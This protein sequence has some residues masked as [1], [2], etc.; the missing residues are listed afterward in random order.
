MTRAI[1]FRI[2]ALVV[3]ALA[4]YGVTPALIAVFGSLDEV[5]DIHP[6]WWIVVVATQAA[7]I[8]C[9]CA[10]QRQAIG[11][12][13]WWPVVSSQLTGA[14][15]GRVIPGGAA[16]AG[17]T[18]LRMLTRAGASVSSAATGVAA[19]SMLLLLVLAGM[20]LAVVPAVLTGLDVPDD[21][22]KTAL[23][24]VGLFAAL[25]AAGVV[26]LASARTVEGLGRAIRW[27]LRRVRLSAPD[28]LPR[29]MHDQV[30]LVRRTVGDR[31]PRALAALDLRL[32][33][34]ARGAGGGRRPTVDRAHPAGLL[35]GAAAG[36]DPDHA[37]RARDRRGGPDQRAGARRG[38]GGVGGRGHAGLP[39]G[40]LL[41][42]VGGGA[43]RLAALPPPDHPSGVR[44]AV[45]AW[46]TIGGPWHLPP[47]SVP[48][49]RRR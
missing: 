5:G 26:L 11:M 42:A 36:P 49:S 22:A 41:A 43:D 32:P 20:P 16:T 34:A 30:D 27:S 12:R 33:D 40:L 47:S 13:R 9:L 10:L 8:A 45:V 46:P 1:A 7:G 31:W 24:G 48:C 19:S 4:L 29:R 21:L 3:A 25:C 6:A 44:F 2:V 18:Q 15:L 17:A 38:R 37:G 28:D 35:R 39:A 14:A 23:L